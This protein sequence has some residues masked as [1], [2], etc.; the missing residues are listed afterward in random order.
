VRTEELIILTMG[1][2]DTKLNSLYNQSVFNT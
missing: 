1:P 2:I